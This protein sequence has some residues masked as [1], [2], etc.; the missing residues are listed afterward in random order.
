ML[1][2]NIVGLFVA[3]IRNSNVKPRV[4]SWSGQI[5]NR[6][7]VF[8]AYQYNLLDFSFIYCRMERKPP[9]KNLISKRIS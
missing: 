3:I 1:T 8:G 7:I 6:Y 4:Q 2:A 5:E 9:T